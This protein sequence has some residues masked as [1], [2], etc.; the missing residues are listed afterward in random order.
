VARSGTV[1]VEELPFGYNTL[2]RRIGGESG[3]D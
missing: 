2:I 3:K 1:I